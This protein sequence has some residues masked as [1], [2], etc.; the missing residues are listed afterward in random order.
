MKKGKYHS[1]LRGEKA[2][3]QRLNDSVK[4]KQAISGKT[5]GSGPAT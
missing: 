5:W 1:H 3:I 4:D 2:E